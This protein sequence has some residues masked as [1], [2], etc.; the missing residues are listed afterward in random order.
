M[1]HA[2]P[3]EPGGPQRCGHGGDLDPGLSTGEP[4]EQGGDGAVGAGVGRSERGAVAGGAAVQLVVG[5]ED[6]DGGGSRGEPGGAVGG[7]VGEFLRGAGRLDSDDRLRQQGQPP[8]QRV[9]VGAQPGGSYG[10]ADDGVDLRGFG[11]HRQM[12]LAARVQAL[13]AVRRGEGGGGEVHDGQPGHVGAGLDVAAQVE[14]AHVGQVDVDEGHVGQGARAQPYV[15]FGECRPAGGGRGD[16]VAGPA[17]Q[18]GHGEAAG[19][20]VVHDQYGQLGPPAA[21]V[22][23]LDSRTHRWSRPVRGLLHQGNAIVREYG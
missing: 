1:L 4:A 15:E 12:G 3:E 7:G 9:V 20:G 22:H 16:L 11:G 6:E 21:C 5:A 17:Q 2:G 14:A 10:G 13:A 8:G 19:R 18:L 23:P